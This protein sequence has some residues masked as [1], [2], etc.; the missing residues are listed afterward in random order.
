MA[1][2]TRPVR[3][4]DS[5]RKIHPLF[6]TLILAALLLPGTLSAQ[7]IL[8]IATPADARTH[9]LESLRTIVA[10]EGVPLPANLSA[11][12]KNRTAAR[13]LGKALFHDMALSSDGVQSCASCHF[14]AGADNRAKNQLTPGLLRVKNRRNGN[15]HGYRNAPTDEDT[16][17]HTKVKGPNSTLN[18]HD[19]PFVKDIGDGSNVVIDGG[20]VSPAPGNS[21]DVA[22]SQGVRR[23]QFVGLKP[24]ADGSSYASDDDG[25]AIYDPVF[26]VNGIGTRRVEPRNTPTT[27]NAV[28]NSAQ[29]WDGRAEP[30]FNGVNP[31]GKQDKAARVYRASKNKGV[32]VPFKPNF[33]N[34]SLASQASGPPLSHFEMSFGDGDAN[35]RVW[36]ELG[37]KMLSRYALEGQEVAPGDSM[38][39]RLRDSAGNGLSVTY[40]DLVKRA[41]PARYWDTSRLVRV[42]APV[43]EEMPGNQFAINNGSVQFVGPN[44][45]ENENTFSLAEVNFSFFASTALMMYQATL[46]TDQTPFDNWMR[47]DGSF[48]RG[49]GQAELDGLNVFVDRGKCLACHAGP[50]LTG[51]SVRHTDGGKLAIEAMLMGDS[52]PAL[53]DN[54]FYNIGVTPT[55]DD[56][57]RGDQDPFG[58]PLSSSRQFAL[59]ALG[60]K[61]FGFPI[62]GAP[63]RDVVCKPDDLDPTACAAGGIL[64]FDDEEGLG[65]FPVC[66]DLNGDGACGVSDRLLLKRVAVDGAFK[67]PGLRN[68]ELTGPYFHNGGVA[69]LRE[70]VDFYDRGGN[71]CKFNF[72][73]LDPAITPLG[74]SEREK[75]N[76]VDFL[77]SLTDPRVKRKRA[78]F[79]HPSFVVP[80]GHPGNENHV[81][82]SGGYGHADDKLMKIAAVGRR[83]VPAADALRPFLNVN[84]HSANAVTGG[85]CSPGSTTN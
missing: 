40:K 68:V 57:G 51:A 60:K 43:Q 47:G 19:F 74:L 8:P 13:R 2:Q 69:T 26:N 59:E 45:S 30:D 6:G 21:N 52:R 32:I 63:I 38:F 48:V 34:G 73:D 76:L 15:V 36:A 27:L 71:F 24:S 35:F 65:F 44:A 67:T 46:V 39:G 78:P 12:V 70:V 9:G 82:D 11:F 85:M 3:P 10:T 31:F 81:L 16:W 33:K 79:D 58:A 66:Q 64:G 25:F 23:T 50:E 20:T 41:F 83:G 56:L 49:F 54:G 22:S 80:N 1:M 53:Y 84:P 55:V 7:G 29:F 75:R 4:F 42:G 17:F 5:S 77:I 28:F 62:E 37:R 72:A 61:K 18:R 14:H